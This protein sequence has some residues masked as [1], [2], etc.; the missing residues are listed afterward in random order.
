MEWR[1]TVEILGGTAVLGKKLKSGVDFARL[2]EH[3]LPGRAVTFLKAYSRL[4]EKDLSSVIPRRTL[5]SLRSTKRLSPEQSDRVAR[6]A[7]T[8]AFAERVFGNL[9]AAREWLLTPNPAL[10]GEIPLSLLRT[11]SGADVVENVLIRIEDGV[12]E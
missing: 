8:V 10:N 7:A 1:E 6:T 2:V 3:G 12:Y 4:S 11:G 9:E 5:T